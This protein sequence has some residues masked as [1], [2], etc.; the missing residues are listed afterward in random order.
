MTPF[1]QRLSGRVDHA[2]VDKTGIVGRFSFH[3]EFT[4][5]HSMGGQALPVGRGGD[6]SGPASTNPSPPADT[7]PTIFAALQEQIGMKLSPDR[8]TV[9]FLIIDQVERLNIE[10]G[11]A[12]ISVCVED[13]HAPIVGRAVP[14]VFHIRPPALRQH[15]VLALA[16]ALVSGAVCHTTRFMAQRGPNL[17][18][19]F[20]LDDR[21]TVKVRNGAEANL[22]AR[23]QPSRPS[24]LG[25][26]IRRILRSS[27]RFLR[28][29]TIRNSSS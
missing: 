9:N 18:G 10:Q 25:L 6:P 22:A 2:V 27:H 12:A 20:T 17:K 21:R 4:P 11:D 26:P 23:M 3:L 29:Q 24:G 15:A 14:S 28:S 8:G 1:A 19:D 7:G 13:H 5:D 16:D